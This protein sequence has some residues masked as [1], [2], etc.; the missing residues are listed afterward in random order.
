MNTAD[1]SARFAA[2]RASRRGRATLWNTADRS[3]RF[4]ALRTSRRGRATLWN[5]R[6][7]FALLSAGILVRCNCEEEQFLPSV[8]YDPFPF[9][10][11][12]SEAPGT[13]LVFGDVSVNSEKTL[14][15]RV[16]SNGRAPVNIV[17]TT[18]DTSSAQGTWTVKVEDDLAPP[19]GIAPGR[20]STISV[21]FRPCPAAWNG[22][23]LKPEFDFNT[24]PGE[25]QAGDLDVT[26]NTRLGTATFGLSG[27]PVQPPIASVWCPVGPNCGEANPQLRE[28]NGVTFGSVSAG[29]EPCD[30]VIE[31]RNNW[32]DNKPVG[33]LEI[34]QIEVLVQDYCCGDPGAI[35]AGE[36]VGFT[37]QDMNGNDLT[38]DPGRPF[39]VPISPGGTEG[40]NRFKFVFSGARTGIWRGQLS[41]MTG[42]RL[43]TNDPDQR[44]ISVPV[45]GQGSAPQLACTP[46][47]HNYG[48]VEQGTT[49]TATI[50]C[51]NAGDAELLISSIAV[52]SGNPEFAV[53]TDLGGTS[54]LRL[55]LFEQVMVFVSYTP[56]D[57]GIDA[58]QLILTSNDPLNP[59]IEISLRGG[60][61]PEIEVQPNDTL[62]FPLPPNQDPPYPPQS[63]SLTVS[64]VGYGDLNITRLELRGPDDTLDHPSVDDFTIPDCSGQNPCN[65]NKT[66]CA[67]GT[68]GCGT[69][70]SDT[71]EIIYDNNDISTI[72]L[73]ELH[74][75]SDDPSDP[76]HIVVL[77][78]EDEPCLFPTP[79]ITVTSPAP[80]CV[81]R[82]VV[83]DATNSNAPPPAT[84]TSCQWRFLFQPCSP[85]TMFNTQGALIS[86]FTPQCDGTFVVGLD[87]TNSC[88]SMSQMPGQ[89][90]VLVSATC[91]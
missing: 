23:E 41:N 64:N 28:C 72:D 37:I 57:T 53:S 46:A 73:A 74:I 31:I 30:L 85:A 36:D 61:V 80:Q 16:Q 47:Q 56:R 89:E 20:T 63:Q 9:V 25:G 71:I 33:D 81:G 34:Q 17:G 39:V 13:E 5:N 54:N 86:S 69:N 87:C 91:P 51:R 15:I 44:L 65:I 52:E 29:E 11:S 7:L 45:T 90:T 67:P 49:R 21:T 12:P 18:L 4:A 77:E 84:I 22:N 60:A 35:V 68:G 43:S 58:E 70:F 59:R 76:E 10:M 6:L 40:M 1:R 14:A 50:S 38:P 78:A 2:L 66:L 42:L 88:G 75:F 79:T 82:D 62:S 3:A 8:T 32:R 19:G 55:Q 26:D 24:C 83:V 48:P 27:R